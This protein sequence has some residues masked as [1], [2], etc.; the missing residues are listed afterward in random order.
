LRGPK[1]SGCW[2]KYAGQLT[3]AVRVRRLWL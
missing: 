1:R 2:T 3:P